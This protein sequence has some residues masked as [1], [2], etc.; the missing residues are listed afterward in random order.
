MNGDIISEVLIK[1]DKKICTSSDIR[2]IFKANYLVTIS[3]LINSKWL[4]PIKNF[5]GFYYVCDTEERQKGFRKLDGLEILV[6]TLNILFGDEWYFGRISSL[7]LS[8]NID[9]AISVYY[10]FNKKLSKEI[11]SKIM[12]MVIFV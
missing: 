8:G 5:K 12:G 2:K 11:K 7:A 4:L 1:R 9:Q 6:R 3:R 10:V